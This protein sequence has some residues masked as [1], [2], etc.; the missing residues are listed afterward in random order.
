MY[1]FVDLDSDNDGVPD[2]ME[3]SLGFEPCNTDSD[4][5]GCPDG[6]QA[7]FGDCERWLH[8]LIDQ[9]EFGP[10]VKQVTFRVPEGLGSDVALHLELDDFPG[11][12]PVPRDAL[13][14]IFAPGASS[15]DGGVPRLED[16]FRG[17]QAGTDITFELTF[18]RPTPLVLDATFGRLQLKDEQGETVGT[19]NLLAEFR[20]LIKL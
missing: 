3:A 20:P 17:V 16:T 11:A 12:R 9:E 7:L 15:L 5:D 1:D 18:V 6:A 4:G 13:Q 19:V 2:A 14:S 8:V 10:V